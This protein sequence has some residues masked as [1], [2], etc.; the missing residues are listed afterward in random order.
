[1][2]R[3]LLESGYISEPDLS[4]FKVTSSV[5][6][7]VEE[8]VHFY[9]VFHS[10]RFVGDKLVLR[11]QR[12]LGPDLVE[13]INIEFD[14]IL[15]GGRFVET[16]P[17]KEEWNDEHLAGMSRLVFRF[18]RKGLGRLRQLIDLLN[19]T[20]DCEPRGRVGLVVER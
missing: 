5:A 17:L 8:I 18:D 1:M 9:S 15:A 2:R 7:A 6:E 14:D 10:M 16:G 19:G 20:P 12:S 13:R 3:N 11:L 4:L